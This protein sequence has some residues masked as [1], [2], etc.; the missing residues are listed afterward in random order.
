MY[1]LTGDWESV[2]H[3]ER[4]KVGCEQSDA[5]LKRHGFGIITGL[6]VPTRQRR[7]IGAGVVAV[8]GCAVPDY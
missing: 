4:E 2:K 5:A 6:G 8:F 1:M 3:C 7:G